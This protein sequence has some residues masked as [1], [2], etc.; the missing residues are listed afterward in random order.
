MTSYKQTPPLKFL[1][2]SLK[3]CRC[4]EDFLLVFDLMLQ[5][6]KAEELDVII[7][8]KKK[9][10]TIKT[11]DEL[12]YQLHMYNPNRRYKHC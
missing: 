1:F 2:H 9:C 7:A 6:L 3:L 11:T 10:N 4:E 8:E 5:N 12:L